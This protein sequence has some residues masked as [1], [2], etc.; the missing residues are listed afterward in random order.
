MPRK[1]VL[2]AVVILAGGWTMTSLAG[3]AGKGDGV[4]KA[5][6]MHVVIFYVKKD[7]PDD[8]A[9]GLIEDSHKILAKI[10]SVRQ[11]WVGRPAKEAT[12]KFAV[13]D[14]TVALTIAF[15]NADG[16]KLYLDHDLHKQYVAKHTK[17]IE[18]ILVYDF[19]NQIK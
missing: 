12:P 15:D 16:L 3:G 19:I 11:L 5:P 14:Y 1:L 6:Y 7:A 13:S 18:K 4:K 9:K 17:N 10:P 8:A 2:L